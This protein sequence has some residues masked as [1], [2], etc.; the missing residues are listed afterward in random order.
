MVGTKIPVPKAC[1]QEELLLSQ[2]PSVS[3]GQKTLQYGDTHTL[4]ASTRGHLDK[5]PTAAGAP[6]PYGGS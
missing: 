1:P 6:V 5:T 2:A 4:A 3:R